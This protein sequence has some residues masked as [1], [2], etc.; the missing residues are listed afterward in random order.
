[1]VRLARRRPRALRLTERFWPGALTLVVRADEGV[2]PEYLQAADPLR[3]EEGGTVALR[4][5]GSEFIEAR[6]AAVDAPLAQTSANLHGRPAATSADELDPAIVRDVELVVDGG[7]APL[8]QASTI[9][10][11]TGPAPRVLRAGAI[12]PALVLAVAAGE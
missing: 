7:P 12:D 9:V 1:M 11:C 2:D 8:A 5:P 10:D 3:P 6:L 4:A